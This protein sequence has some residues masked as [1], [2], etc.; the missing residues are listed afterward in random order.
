MKYILCK[1]IFSYFTNISTDFKIIFLEYIKNFYKTWRVA[2]CINSYHRRDVDFATKMKNF[3]ALY[4]EKPASG[5][6][7]YRRYDL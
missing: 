7:A 1:Y 4:L 3:C 6:N 5:D 2:I